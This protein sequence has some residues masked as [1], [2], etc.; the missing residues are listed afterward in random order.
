MSQP[1]L[2]RDDATPLEAAQ[3]GAEKRRHK[4]RS[5]MWSAHLELGQDKRVGCVV[6][7]LS[8]GG[9]K[10]LLKE[11]VAKSKIVTLISDRVGSRGGRIVWADGN[12]VGIEFL[13]GSAE[14]VGMTAAPYRPEFTAS[15]APAPEPPPAGLDARFL[16]G[17]AVVLRRLAGTNP[18]RKKAA[19][20]LQSARS[21]E[22]E[23]AQLDDRQMVSG[24][25]DV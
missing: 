24:S 21:M 12:R 14:I 19:T 9:A 10:L 15:P 8:D 3:S 4:R 23:A 6:L 17:R 22:A 5:G 20:L 13:A 11:P 25:S 1:N 18:D 16:R 2:K 7:D